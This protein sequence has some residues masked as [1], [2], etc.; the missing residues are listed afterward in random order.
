MWAL[1]CVLYEMATGKPPFA[2]TGLKELISQ[3]C[4]STEFPRVEGFSPAFNDL[5]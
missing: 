1:G 4:E 2:A 3:I 5:L